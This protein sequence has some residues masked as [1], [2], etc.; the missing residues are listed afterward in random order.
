MKLLSLLALFV[1]LSF[2]T[3]GTARVRGERQMGQRDK[4]KRT[5]TPEGCKALSIDA[6]FPTPDVWTAALPGIQPRKIAADGPKRPDYRFTAR[7][8]DDVEKAVQFAAQHNVRLTIINT[9]HDYQGRNDAPSGL[10]LDVSQLRGVNVLPS[11]TPSPQGV[12]SPVNGAPVNVIPEEDRNGAAVT[13]GCGIV[14]SELNRA[15]ND[16]KIFVVAGA[17]RE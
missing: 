4:F 6:E 10:S 14:G 5:S 11:F 7:S 9:G 1:H 17:S 3:A 13:F 12:E 8:P 16:S 2:C 15:I